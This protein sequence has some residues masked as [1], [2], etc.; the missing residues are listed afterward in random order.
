MAADKPPVELVKGVNGLEKLVL[1]EVRGGSAEVRVNL[2][3]YCLF[4]VILDDYSSIRD[5][6]GPLYSLIL[7]L[8]LLSLSLDA[9]CFDYWTDF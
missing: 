7:V 8:L 5:G 6:S 4:F 3:I 9:D 1:R 2:S